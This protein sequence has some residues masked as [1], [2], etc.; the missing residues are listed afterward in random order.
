MAVRPVTSL[1][2]SVSVPCCNDCKESRKSADG[3]SHRRRWS[4]TTAAGPRG[5]TTGPR[6][7]RA[8]LLTA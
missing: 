5:P 4:V 2:V 7:P 3:C 1:H 8:V 6:P